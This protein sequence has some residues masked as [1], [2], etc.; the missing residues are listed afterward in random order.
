MGV[1]EST[2]IAVRRPQH[3]SGEEGAVPKKQA[4]DARESRAIARTEKPTSSFVGIA[5]RK[6]SP[7]R[8]MEPQQYASFEMTAHVLPY[9][10]EN[11]ETPRAATGVVPGASGSVVP[12]PSWP[13][14][15]SP[16]HRRSPVSKRAQP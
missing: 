10:R 7:S 6:S 13:K 3:L 12:T 5:A 8:K 15:L 1:L 2:P 16:Q 14:E 11:W 4:C 9:P